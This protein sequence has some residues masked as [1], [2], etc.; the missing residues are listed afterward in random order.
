MQYL[1]IFIFLISCADN[2]TNNLQPEKID[3]LP[4]D[5]SIDV[6]YSDATILDSSTNSDGGSPVATLRDAGSHIIDQDASGIIPKFN[7]CDNSCTSDINIYYNCYK[8]EV[9]CIISFYHHP[10]WQNLCAADKKYCNFPNWETWCYSERNY[11]NLACEKS[12]KKCSDD[13]GCH[14][15]L[16]DCPSACSVDYLGN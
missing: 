14:L 5:A 11:C 8:E 3:P 6:I 13:N 10:E 12:C 15:S 2:N 9:A 1:L 4:I 16:D 7:T